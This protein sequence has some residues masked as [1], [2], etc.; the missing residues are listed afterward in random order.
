MKISNILSLATVATIND[1]LYGRYGAIRGAI[2]G[3]HH[4]H[5]QMIITNHKRLSNISIYIVLFIMVICFSITM[6]LLTQMLLSTTSTSTT[7]TM[8][9]FD[10]YNITIYSGNNGDGLFS[11]AKLAES[12]FSLETFLSNINTSYTYDD[13]IFSSNN[14]R[15]FGHQQKTTDEW[16]DYWQPVCSSGDKFYVFSAYIDSYNRS[17]LN[18]NFFD[19]NHH[20]NDNQDYF[21]R[22]IA[23]TQ[24]TSKEKIICAFY[25]TTTTIEEDSEKQSTTSSWFRHGKMKPIREHWNLQFSAFFIYCPLPK[26][27]IIQND[28]GKMKTNYHL[29][30]MAI[31]KQWHVDG[32]DGEEFHRLLKRNVQI[33]KTIVPSNRLP[34]HGLQQQI[35]QPDDDNDD[36]KRFDDE[37]KMMMAICVKP[38]HY[39]YNK[40]I[41]LMEFIELNRLLGVKRFY[42]FNHTISSQVNHLLQL[43]QHY[44]PD[45]LN[46]FQWQLPI[47]SQT[48]IRTEGIFAAL[49]DCLYRARYNR[50]RYVMF[51][52]LDEFIMPNNHQNLIDLLHDV[53]QFYPNKIGAFSFRNGFFYLQYPD[54]NQQQ[55]QIGK[56]IN[57]D[58]LHHKLIT[59]TKTWR[60]I[61]LNI[62]KQRS[63]CIVL[64][65]NVVEM[66]NHFVWEFTYGKHTL[67]IDPKIAYLHHYRVCEFGGDNCI[68]D[69]EHII[70]RRAY[71]W[72]PSLLNNIHRRL[73]I[74]CDSMPQQLNDAC[75]YRHH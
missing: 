58:N 19:S 52:D 30:I 14:F 38:L 44:E 69:S 73:Q 24:L 32:D 15:C 36:G 6:I 59:L 21:V 34:I 71:Y 39:Y 67:N 27:V 2:F 45:L 35:N 68:N 7:T 5:H 51:I 64:P 63:K 65:E 43:Y 55:Q 41:N 74:F 8:D 66:G 40:T 33:L 62:H 29:S 22:I 53:E 9:Q 18:L 16:I 1:Q 46:I 23:V 70:D 54:D 11:A 25:S 20:H 56:S 47:K 49:N 50:F 17:N 75:N 4:H 26:T 61:N 48:E 42:F 12:H 3:H 31:S 57:N 60:K 72:A 13:N 10:S 28:H 37:N